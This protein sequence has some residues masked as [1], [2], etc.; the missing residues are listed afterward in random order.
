MLIIH[1]IIIAQSPYKL[2]LQFI[3]FIFTKR[4]LILLTEYLEGDFETA[5]NYAFKLN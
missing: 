5:L 2:R 3:R 4:L 1:Y